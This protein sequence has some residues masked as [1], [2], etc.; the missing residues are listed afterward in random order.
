MF[1]VVMAFTFQGIAVIHSKLGPR[2]KG[3]L[4]LVF[5][6]ILLLVLLPQVVALTAITGVLDNWLVFRKQPVKPSD[7]N[8]L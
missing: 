7:E 3:R 5:Y 8:E 1:L 4:M 6:Y 2:N